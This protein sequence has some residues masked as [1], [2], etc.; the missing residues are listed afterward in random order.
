[1]LTD[2]KT[3]I[4]IRHA[5]SSWDNPGMSDIERPLNNRGLRDAPFMAN[6]L[7]E[8]GT[9]PDLI[10]TSPANR[11]YE[12]SKFF[13]KALSYPIELIQK[14]ELIYSSGPKDILK[15][16]NQADD[17]YN[18]IMLFGHNPDLSTLSNYLS[19]NNFESLPTCGVICIDFHIDSWAMMDEESG[20]VR[21]FEY[22]KKYFKK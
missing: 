3:L 8:K 21:F 22:P 19:N 11:A 20:K 15:I 6:L 4:L 9:K 7:K 12:T 16:I 1:L 14:K 2:L 5:K 18:C 10:F 17:S 13:A